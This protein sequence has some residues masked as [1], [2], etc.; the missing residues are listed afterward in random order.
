MERDPKQ[1]RVFC[2]HICFTKQ[3]W[4]M[5]GLEI[6]LVLGQ[7]CPTTSFQNV[8]GMKHGAHLKCRGLYVPFPPYS[9]TTLY[10][11]GQG[12]GGEGRHKKHSPRYDIYRVIKKKKSPS[13]YK[14]LTHSEDVLLPQQN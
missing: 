9:R 2:I 8:A 4:G 3:K 6:A 13:K 1:V 11:G 5:A 10:K 7:V 12:M 14:E